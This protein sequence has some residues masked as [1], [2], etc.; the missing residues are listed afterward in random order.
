MTLALSAVQLEALDRWAAGTTERIWLAEMDLGPTAT[1]QVLDAGAGMDLMSVTVDLL[2]SAGI[3]VLSGGPI[4][5]TENTHWDREAGDL[6]S[7]AQNICN[8]INEDLDINNRVSA[9]A[10]GAL[11]VVHGVGVDGRARLQD[12]ERIVLTTSS[13]THIDQTLKPIWR[14]YYFTDRE[15]A[16]FDAT[17]IA[18]RIR[19]IPELN[20]V[21][22]KASRIDPISRDVS[23][24]EAEL[25]FDDTEYRG[26]FRELVSLGFVSGK[27]VRLYWLDELLSVNNAVPV[28]G[29][30]IKEPPDT[31]F[32]QI[33][34]QLEALPAVL[35]RSQY[36]N[37]NGPVPLIWFSDSSDLVGTSRVIHF[38]AQT[39]AGDFEYTL[40]ETT[41]TP[42]SGEFQVPAVAGTVAG[43]LD[44][45]A[46]I[47]HQFN[48]DTNN[49]IR[50]Y[51]SLMWN[52]SSSGDI[53]FAF[54]PWPASSQSPLDH[55]DR[56]YSLSIFLDDLPW[57]GTAAVQGITTP[58]VPGI[59]DGPNG[60]SGYTAP[61]DG[62][63]LFGVR[64]E[65]YWTINPGTFGPYRRPELEY[66]VN[67]LSS[68]NSI[69]P[70]DLFR[71]VFRVA[72]Q[73]VTFNEASFDLANHP[74]V[75]HHLISPSWL[76]S[77]LVASDLRNGGN[78]MTDG[79]DG[80]PRSARGVIQD[81]QKLT[82][83]SVVQDE[84]ITFRFTRREKTAT[85][86]R[87]LSQDDIE[88]FRP[89]A[90]I[91]TKVNKIHFYGTAYG[92]DH[93]A[94]LL[95]AEDLH[96]QSAHSAAVDT[97]PDEMIEEHMMLGNFTRLPIT[98]NNR[99]DIL[100]TGFDNDA[101]VM[102]LVQ[103]YETGFSGTRQTQTGDPATIT[104][105][106][107][108]DATLTATR[109]AYF[110]LWSW[111][112]FRREGRFEIVKCTTPPVALTSSAGDAYNTPSPVGPRGQV[113]FAPGMPISSTNIS[114]ETDDMGRPGSNDTTEPYTSA[115]SSFT[116]TIERAQ[117]GS[118]DQNWGLIHWNRFDLSDFQFIQGDEV[119]V[120]DLTVAKNYV[121][122]LMDF[123]F[124]VPQYEFETTQRHW[125]LQLGDVLYLTHPQVLIP[126]H[127]GVVSG[128]D[129]VTW[130]IVEK[131]PS[132]SK[133]KFR[134]AL[135]RNEFAP[136]QTGRTYTA[137]TGIFTPGTGGGAGG[138]AVDDPVTDNNLVTVTSNGYETVYRG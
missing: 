65:T 115:I 5:Y 75:S 72:G 32:G 130:E 109:P 101:T 18:N 78:P 61:V 9:Y 36:D 2:D 6:A 114:T 50:P 20:T 22:V 111:L 133:V 57:R 106:Q 10:F 136:P 138:G 27:M 110:L 121:D 86:V 54:V 137:P 37:T 62:M 132:G 85:P 120:A 74:T 35:E 96:S 49:Q 82:Q 80:A 45:V 116:W 103:C 42:G 59:L 118:Q 4:S 94:H 98:F 40:T 117:L 44:L 83:G 28:G 79:A 68:A 135:L 19:I 33:S 113:L 55:K 3:T 104:F 46:H 90:A 73:G 66:L 43:H 99:H 64:D 26:I 58:A 97:S 89:A 47:C 31:D 91:K 34:L 53:G 92:H 93:K 7:T 107:P 108:A 16:V 24:G 131:E 105:S 56:P 39:S 69:H 95:S 119:Y 84:D 15:Y 48:T 124:P 41:S 134:V 1:L 13:A 30:L 125:D 81:L 67:P 25:I 123:S 77:S 70:I 87:T 112:E 29:G 52:G 14:T 129:D 126:F 38:R 128:V 51:A 100:G 23:I 71:D 63:Y 102:D 17:D 60:T 127:N 76:Q 88:N 21:D 11:I 12:F 8:A 122:H